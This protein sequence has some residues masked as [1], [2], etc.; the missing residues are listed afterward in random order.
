MDA[1]GGSQEMEIS[2]VQLLTGQAGT[3]GAEAKAPVASRWEEG[4]HEGPA[5]FSAGTDRFRHRPSRCAVTSCAL[6]QYETR[7]EIPTPAVYLLLV[8]YLLSVY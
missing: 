5:W 2:D 7:G 1:G 4:F 8:Y 3:L 6:G